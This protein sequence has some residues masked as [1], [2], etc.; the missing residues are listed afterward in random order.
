MAKSLQCEW[1]YLQCVIPNCSSLFAPL[2]HVMLTRF[3]PALFGFEVSPL[4]LHLFSL[5]VCWDGLGLA[6]P[7]ASVC[8]TSLLHRELLRLL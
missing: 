8:L 2:E 1:I 7:C 3:L 4:V 5:P 6:M